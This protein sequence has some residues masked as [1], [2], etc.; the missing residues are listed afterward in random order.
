MSPVA[1]STVPPAVGALAV[2]VAL[3]A[4]LGEPP[5]RLHPV[6]RFGAAVTPFDRD[7]QRPRAVGVVVALCAPLGFAAVYAVPVA[8][9]PGAVGVALAGGL[10]F[11]A[12]SL[13]M[14]L[15]VAEETLVAIES[16]GD[17]PTRPIRALVGRDTDG[18]S[19]GELRS[20]VVESLAENLS[21]GLVA[22]LAAFVAGAAISVPVAVGA[23][24]WVKGVNTLDSMF[25][26]REKPLGW[27]S[28]RLD[29][30]VMYVPARL[31][32]GLIA[33]TAQTPSVLIAAGRWARAPASPNAGWPMATLA[34]ALGVQLRKPDRYALNPA[35][36]LPT[37]DHARRGLQVVRA[38][39]VLAIAAA[40]V[41]VWLAAGLWE[42]IPWW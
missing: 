15:G 26:Y 12:V 2:A 40:G 29:D 32:A 41:C 34:G 21:D 16:D 18:L 3:E 6:A 20:G 19:A 35:S 38:A 7:W 36:E 1:G 11:T 4:A 31:T 27:A 33:A 10:L 8:L 30:A 9:A 23:A 24:A 37:D 5:E 42:A 39:G 25:G 22:P 13:R 28:A 14:L 17:D